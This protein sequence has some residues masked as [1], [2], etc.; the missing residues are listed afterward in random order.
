MIGHL[1]RGYIT[2][3]WIVAYFKNEFTTTQLPILDKNIPL[4]M[5]CKKVEFEIVIK[6]NKK[7]GKIIW[8]NVKQKNVIIK[9]GQMDY[10]YLIFLGNH[11]K[12]V[13]SQKQKT[14]LRNSK[15]Q[16]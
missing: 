9:Y 16:R 7:Y 5:E 11:L 2:K 10:V 4:K 8:E 15:F 1:F 3:Q 6:D 13:F 14:M 12:K